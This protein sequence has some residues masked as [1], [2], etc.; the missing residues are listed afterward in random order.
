[1]RKLKNRLSSKEYYQIYPTGS[2]PGKFYNRTKIHKLPP[3]GFIDNL[4]LRLIVSSIGTANYQ[5]AKYLAKLLSPLAQS[6]YT[7]NTTKDLM[8]NIKN[9]K[10]PENYK[11]AS[12]DV[13]YL[14]TLVPLDTI[15]IKRIYDK[16]EIA[17]VFT[18]NEMKLLTIC[19]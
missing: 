10:I 15:I 8:I 12:F 14:F 13:K 19:T 2:C 3:N 5:L 7:I 9:E 4:P 16:H 1:M 6:N 17:T 11:M 18:K